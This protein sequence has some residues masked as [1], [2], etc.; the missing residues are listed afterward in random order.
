M[1]I[2]IGLYFFGCQIAKTVVEEYV[3]GRQRAM[4][5]MRGQHQTVDKNDIITGH[6]GCRKPQSLE[7]NRQPSDDGQRS[8]M[9]CRKE[10]DLSF[11]ESWVVRLL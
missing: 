6:T 4:E 3:E 11:Y 2:I 7:G 9:I 8:I 10:E 1:V 5:T